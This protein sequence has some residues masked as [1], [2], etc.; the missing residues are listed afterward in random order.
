MFLA[1]P[2]MSSSSAASTA[3]SNSGPNSVRNNGRWA[4]VAAS[5]GDSGQSVPASHNRSASAMKCWYHV[6]SDRCSVKIGA[7]SPFARYS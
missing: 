1:T 3:A 4:R 6:P 2:V 5:E 7:A